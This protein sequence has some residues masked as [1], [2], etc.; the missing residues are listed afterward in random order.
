MSKFFKTLWKIISILFGSNF[1]EIFE[2]AC[3]DINRAFRG[4]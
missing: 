2:K 3:V 4:K 1:T